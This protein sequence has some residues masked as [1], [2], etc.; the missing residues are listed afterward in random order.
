MNYWLLKTETTS[1]S[2][3][4][5]KTDQKT[6]WTGVRNYQARNFIKIMKAGDKFLFYHS[7][8]ALP[9]VYGVGEISK[10]AYPDPTA[11]NKK[12]HHYDPKSTKEKPTWYSVEVKFKNKFKEPYSLFQIK[13][14]SNLRDMVV[15]QRGSRLSVMP[16]DKEHFDL[17][18]RRSK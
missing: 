18:I 14:D 1:Y 5:F 12:D 7:S 9:G 8:S 3:D 11:L 6:E 10:D 4:N 17:I 2:V 13:Q 15:A 16:V